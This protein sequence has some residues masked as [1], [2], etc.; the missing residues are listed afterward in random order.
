MEPSNS[1]KERP[2][3]AGANGPTQ[4]FR[5]LGKKLLT[6]LIPKF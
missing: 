3:I 1:I 6:P 2:I 5:Y 4:R